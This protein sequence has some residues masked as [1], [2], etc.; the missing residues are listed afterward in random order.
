MGGDRGGWTRGF[1]RRRVVGAT[2]SSPSPG[3][4]RLCFGAVWRPAG[5]GGDWGGRDAQLSTSASRRGDGSLPSPGAW[6]LCFGA[7]WRPAAGIREPYALAQPTRSRGYDKEFPSKFAAVA[8]GQGDTAAP[9][10]TSAHTYGPALIDVWALRSRSGKPGY[11]ALAPDAQAESGAV[12]RAERGS[13]PI[14]LPRRER[15]RSTRSRPTKRRALRTLGIFPYPRG[16]PP[17]ACLV[18]RHTHCRD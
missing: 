5:M 15:R 16:S 14:C 11:R 4:W 3:A 10:S 17:V 2:E 6:R 12:P 18:S 13:P 1:S 7:V 9:P 8:V